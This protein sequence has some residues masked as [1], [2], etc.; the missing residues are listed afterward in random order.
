MKDTQVKLS[1][2][3]DVKPIAQKT[4]RVPFHLR[5]KVSKET[6]R[7]Q[8]LDIIE[9]SSGPTPWV[10]PVVIVHKPND[11]IRICLDSRAINTAIERERHPM[12]TIEDLI[13][14]VN[15]SQVFSKIDLNKGYHQ[16]E[17]APESRYITTFATHEGLFRY[18]RLCFGINTAAEIF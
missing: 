4:R 15:G 11:E 6:Q 3:E 8:E 7:L 5:E 9:E 16:I 17:L 10:S 14:E 13:V 18:K 1:I 12:N 2:N